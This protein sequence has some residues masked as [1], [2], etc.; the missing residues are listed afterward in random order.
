MDDIGITSGEAAWL[1]IGAAAAVVVIVVSIILIAL[2]V[3]DW[4][5]G[6]K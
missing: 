2:H 4:W 3:R 1:L 5:R 6:P